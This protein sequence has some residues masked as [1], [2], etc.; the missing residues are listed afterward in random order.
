GVYEAPYVYIFPLLFHTLYQFLHEMASF[1]RRRHFVSV[2]YLK[3]HFFLLFLRHGA[4]SI[5]GQLRTFLY[6][7]SSLR[8]ESIAPV[9]GRCLPA[10]PF[11]VLFYKT[12]REGDYIRFLLKL[13]GERHVCAFVVE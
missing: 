5:D 8:S 10:D 13:P 3:E 2:V 1:V 7:F 9:H 12:L 11:A 4:Y 6:F